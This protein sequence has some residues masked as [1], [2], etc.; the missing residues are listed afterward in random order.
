M[1]A[2]KKT[3]RPNFAA[4]DLMLK[5]LM[6]VQCYTNRINQLALNHSMANSADRMSLLF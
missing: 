3:D 6:V 2:D 5:N 1:L 4:S